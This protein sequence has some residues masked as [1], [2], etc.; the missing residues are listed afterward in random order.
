MSSRPAGP[1]G[2][3]PAAYAYRLPAAG[4]RPHEVGGY[5]VTDEQMDAIEKVCI[6]ERIS[7]HADA[8]I[9]LRIMPSIW[10][11]WRRVISSTVEFSGSRLR[12]AAPHRDELS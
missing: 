5:W 4:F 11:F 12:N 3:R 1:R 9:E 7:R 2:C 10:P 8:R 6:D